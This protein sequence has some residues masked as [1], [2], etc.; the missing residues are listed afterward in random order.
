M[1]EAKSLKRNPS[2]AT[3]EKFESAISCNRG[4]PWFNS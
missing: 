3:A 4:L 1:S 2:S